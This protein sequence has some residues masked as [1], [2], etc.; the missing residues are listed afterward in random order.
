MQD[1]Q[2]GTTFVES[3]VMVKPKAQSATIAHDRPQ[4][5]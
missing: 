1:S 2:A 3:T 4:K 5:E